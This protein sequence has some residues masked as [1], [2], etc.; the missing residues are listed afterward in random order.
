MNY[1]PEIDG[2]RALAVT[3]VILHHFD[4][5]ILPSGFLGVDL[6]FVISGYVITASLWHRN[7]SSTK[8]VLLGF[9]SRRVKRL[10]PA[11]IF[12]VAITSL[13]AFLFSPTPGISIKQAYQR[14][15]GCRI[16][17]YFS[18]PRIILE[19]RRS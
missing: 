8:D 7:H 16:S 5:A 10:V 12:C 15:S 14:C 19:H 1:R 11:L 9:Y 3:A 13:F 2:L 4:R 17:F 18:N 6:F